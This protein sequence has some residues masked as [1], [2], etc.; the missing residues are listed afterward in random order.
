MKTLV[1]LCHMSVV[2]GY[3]QL[4]IQI[5]RGFIKAGWRVKIRPAAIWEPDWGNSKIPND[6]LALFVTGPQPEPD[7]LLLHPPN[8]L[9]TPGKRTTYFTMHETNRLTPLAVSVLNKAHQVVVPCKMNAESF[10]DSG[11]KRPIHVVPLGIDP[12]VFHYHPMPYEYPTIIRF[13][14]AG[15][16][17]HGGV[18]KGINEVVDAFLK[19]FP[20]E[21]DVRLEV[22]GFPDCGINPVCDPR[23]T[24]HQAHWTDAQLAFWYSTLSCFVSASKGEGFGLMQLQALAT[25]RPLI[26]IHWGGVAEFFD[27]SRMGYEL[28]TNLGPAKFAYEGQGMWAVPDE[29]DLIESM[30]AFRLSWATQPFDC[31]SIS[32]EASEF[33]WENMCDRLEEAMQG[34]P[35]Y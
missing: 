27:P 18:R 22:K 7:E 33:T 5:A 11:V 15:R 6:I 8:F 16:M 29:R 4:G 20:T 19:A 24:I 31:E 10:A 12:E 14:C 17:A 3:G 1:M 32:R 13:G 34:A 28:C 25:G 21:K 9:P 23:I 30:R 2:T 35:S 26:S